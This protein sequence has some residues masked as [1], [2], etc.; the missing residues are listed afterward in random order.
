MD[1]SDDKYRVA[2]SLKERNL[3]Q[4]RPLQI[5]V[6]SSVSMLLGFRKGV[7]ASSRLQA[8]RRLHELSHS[9]SDNVCSEYTVYHVCRWQRSSAAT[10]LILSTYCKD[11]CGAQVSYGQSTRCFFSTQPGDFCSH[12]TNI[13]VVIQYSTRY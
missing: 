5:L 12:I 8:R 10:E 7:F 4:P 2:F 6:C 11:L 3:Q 13:S 1:H 9:I